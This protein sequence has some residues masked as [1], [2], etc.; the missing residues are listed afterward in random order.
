[1]KVTAHKPKSKWY[2]PTF[3]IRGIDRETLGLILAFAEGG[4]ITER[5]KYREG[6]QEGKSFPYNSTEELVKS[7]QNYI[8]ADA[9]VRL[10]PLEVE[11]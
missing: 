9:V 3:T 7:L 2:S 1:M 11:T 10:T 5:Q 4:L 8:N 6:H